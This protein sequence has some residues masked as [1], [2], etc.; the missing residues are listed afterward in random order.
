MF[1]RSS[2]SC[3]WLFWKQPTASFNSM[4]LAAF[5]DRSSSG[6]NRLLGPPRRICAIDF[7]QDVP[8]VIGQVPFGV[9]ILKFTDVADPPNVIANSV[10]LLIGPIEFL[11]GNIL[12]GFNRLEHRTTTEATTA[13]YYRLRRFVEPNGNGKRHSPDRNCE[14]CHVPACPYTRGPDREPRSSCTS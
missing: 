4:C 9:M 7:C 14:Y 3:S 5:Q 12:T 13:K 2:C 11:A 6:I 1:E 8:D 10:G